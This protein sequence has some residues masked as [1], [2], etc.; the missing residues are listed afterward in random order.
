MLNGRFQVTGEE[1]ESNSK[2]SDCIHE[3]LYKGLRIGRVE[4][5]NVPHGLLLG[6][7]FLALAVP[8]LFISLCEKWHETRSKRAFE[9]P[10]ASHSIEEKGIV[11]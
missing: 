2:E 5:L 9:G 7:E 3:Q 6:N 11:A 4:G 10:R 8:F 1:F